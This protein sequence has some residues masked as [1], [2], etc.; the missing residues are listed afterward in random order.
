LPRNGRLQG[1]G[2]YVRRRRPWC[3][4]NKSRSG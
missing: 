3:R 2:G 1:V 4:I